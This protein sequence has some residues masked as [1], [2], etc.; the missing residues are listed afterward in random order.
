MGGRFYAENMKNK[1]T[2]FLY[3]KE[4]HTQ[5]TERLDPTLGTLAF[6]CVGGA[7]S[8]PTTDFLVM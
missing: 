6:C 3:Q 4:Q 5:T 2:L 8:T 1:E 7:L